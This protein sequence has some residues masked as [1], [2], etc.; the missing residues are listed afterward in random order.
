MKD[1]NGDSVEDVAVAAPDASPGGLTNAGIAYLVY[2]N[3]TL[4]GADVSDYAALQATGFELDGTQAGE[5][6]GWKMI[7]PGDLDGDGYNDWV[8]A[9]PNRSYAGRN[10]CGAVI[11]IYGQ[12]TLLTG[13]GTVDDVVSKLG[14]TVIYGAN[15]GD[16]LGGVTPENAGP[17]TGGSEAALCS[18]MAAV[19]DVDKD[20]YPDFVVSAPGYG[21]LNKP[22][23]GAV[24]LIYGGPH[25]KGA[26]LDLRDIGTPQTAGQ[27]VHRSGAECRGRS[28]CDGRRYRW[29][30]L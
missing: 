15:A 26:Q 9:S 14:G 8:L 28:G 30:L 21:T 24:Y 13:Q 1:F 2:G 7:G 3:K 12:P 10:N 16:M 4:R 22:H 20:G 6:L 19:G 25:L 11:I 23:C 18:Y 17:L 27:D 5:H 29:R